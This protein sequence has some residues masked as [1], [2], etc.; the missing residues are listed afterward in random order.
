MTSRPTGSGSL[1]LYVGPM[2][3]SKTTRLIHAITIYADTGKKVLYVNHSID[4]RGAAGQNETGVTTHNTNFKGLSSKVDW[5]KVSKLQDLSSKVD[6]YD[7]IGIDE[8]QFFGDLEMMVR[9]WVNQKGKHVVCAG[10]DGDAEMKPF[11]QI[12]NLVPI[13]DN[14]VK[15]KAS[16]E[17][18]R[19]QIEE[20]HRVGLSMQ[21]LQ[22]AP[23]TRKKVVSTNGPDKQVEVGG[24]DVYE[25]VCRY[26]HHHPSKIDLALK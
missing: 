17:W 12:L 4:N 24:A 22:D 21:P 16:C 14:I 26:H 3:S 1:L 5:V 6:D 13:C 19:L 18:C 23:F 11:G 25:P 2:F 8:S 15:L 9:Q 7:V 10:L 20:F